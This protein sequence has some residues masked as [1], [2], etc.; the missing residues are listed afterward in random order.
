MGSEC[1][2]GSIT[3]DDLL[4][5]TT[6]Y[7]TMLV[8][9]CVAS[10]IYLM[11]L[12][13]IASKNERW[14]ARAA[15][16]FE[17]KSTRI[18]V[19]AKTMVMVLIASIWRSFFDQW[20][21]DH[22]F[23]EQ[24]IWGL[25]TTILIVGVCVYGMSQIP[26]LAYY[27]LVL[28]LLL[29]ITLYLNLP[30]WQNLLTAI[31]LLLAGFIAYATSGYTELFIAEV[32]MAVVSSESIVYASLYMNSADKLKLV[33]ATNDI[34][35]GSDCFRQYTCI[36]HFVA[37]V[38]LISVQLTLLFIWCIVRCCHSTTSTPAADDADEATTA[39]TIDVVI[40]TNEDSTHQED[41]EMTTLSRPRG[42]TLGEEEEELEEEQ[43]EGRVRRSGIGSM[44]ARPPRRASRSYS[45]T[46]SSQHRKLI[47]T[48]D[49]T[50][51]LEAAAAVDSS[52]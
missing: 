8:L 49:I 35:A 32:L 25:L 5:H 36:H 13:L 4:S 14:W 48:V 18:G 6:L 30:G 47:Y 22:N 37:S 40:P 12:I 2:L 50:D 33:D 34:K 26:K 21:L 46:A 42:T 45:S 1:S 43:V 31:C 17:T 51:A 27:L 28:V 23:G 44:G 7:G 29:L 52:E 9:A 20:C 39:A 3:C 15:Y 10:L 16:D 11:P 38:C 41:V 24:P 19:M